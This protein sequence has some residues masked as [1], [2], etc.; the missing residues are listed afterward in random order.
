MDLW[1]GLALVEGFFAPKCF[2]EKLLSVEQS[3]N[4]FYSFL[5]ATVSGQL[6]AEEGPGAEGFRVQA[7]AVTPGQNWEWQQLMM[8]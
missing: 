6:H 7:Q 8:T 1:M 5:S 3:Q 4:L 2:R